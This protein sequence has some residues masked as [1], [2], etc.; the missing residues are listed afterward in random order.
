MFSEVNEKLHGCEVADV[1]HLSNLLHCLLLYFWHVVL[2]LTGMSKKVLNY[3]LHEYTVV[4]LSCHSR[5]GSHHTLPNES[6][7]KIAATSTSLPTDS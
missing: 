1:R 6:M 4:S 7:L 2:S 5:V 3:F